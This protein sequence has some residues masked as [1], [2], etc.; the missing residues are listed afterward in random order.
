[1]LGNKSNI[2]YISSELAQCI[3][4]FDK[5]ALIPFPTPDPSRFRGILDE[6]MGF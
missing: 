2:H 5:N 4:D 6:E 1:M 3:R